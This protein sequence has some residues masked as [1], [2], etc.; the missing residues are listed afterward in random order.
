[1]QQGRRGSRKR[2]QTPLSTQLSRARTGSLW[3]FYVRPLVANRKVGSQIVS[4]DQSR[5][6]GR[7][8]VGR[9][10]IRGRR[11]SDRMKER[12]HR[13]SVRFRRDKQVT[14]NASALALAMTDEACWEAEM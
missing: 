6:P 10:G 1:M 5:L 8:T 13:F 9:V 11:A 3:L 4:K 7:R 2:N 14:C 12:I